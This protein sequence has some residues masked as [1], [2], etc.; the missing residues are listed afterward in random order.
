MSARL[1]ELV[2]RALERGYEVDAVDTQ[3]PRHATEISRDAARD[4]YD[5][6]VA[7]G[8]DGTINEAANGLA[9]T[10]TALPAFRAAPPTSTAA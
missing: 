4:G 3:R 5:A 9:G 7:L 2:V 1:K 6:V 10:D 8:G